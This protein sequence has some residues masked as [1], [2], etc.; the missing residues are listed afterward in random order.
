[1]ASFAS[2][3]KLG[4]TWPDASD[5]IR[6]HCGAIEDA[7]TIAAVANAPPKIIK[8]ITATM[9]FPLGRHLQTPVDNFANP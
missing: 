8:L 5:M 1:V 4:S 6:C 7:I 3:E 9:V 2:G